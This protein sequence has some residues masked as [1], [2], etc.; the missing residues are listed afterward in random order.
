MSSELKPDGSIVT[1][2]DREVEEFLRR[3]LGPLIPGATTWGEEFGHEEPAAEGY[4]LIDPIDGTSNFRFGLPLWGITVGFMK[5]GVLEVGCVSLPDLGWCLAAARGHGATC[6]G[7]PMPMIPEGNIRDEQLMG[8][9]DSKTFAI[10][11]PGKMRHVGSFVAEAAMVA[12]QNLRAM[13]SSRAK[14]YDAAGGVVICREVGAEIRE[15]DG[16]TWNEADWQQPKQMN[17]F[18]IGPPRS[19]F[20]FQQEGS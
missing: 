19:N 8:H 6:N 16:T 12:R 7:E 15:L 18:V 5:D 13:A 11:W 4:W 10:K 14:L 3:Q 9:G 1:N 20:P 17:S 2:A